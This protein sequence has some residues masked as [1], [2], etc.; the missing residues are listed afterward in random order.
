M[1]IGA[2]IKLLRVKNQLTLEELANRSELTK[3]FLSQ[4]ERNL[5]SPSIATLEDILEALGTT[6]ENFSPMT[7]MKKLFL[8]RAIILL[9]NR[10][11]IIF[12]ILCRMHRRTVWNRFCC[13]CIRAVN[14]RSM[15]RMKQKSLVMF[16]REKWN[17]ITVRSNII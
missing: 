5:T 16:C 3:G 10:K 4:V 7:G 8:R 13:S 1:D 2:K 6:L 15:A 11:G 12:L 17:C 9:M 14:R